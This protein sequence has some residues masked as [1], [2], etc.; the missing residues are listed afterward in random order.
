MLLVGAG[1]GMGA[2]AV[3]ADAIV[4]DGI[5]GNS[6]EQ[7]EALV[8][9]APSEALA[10][11]VVCDRYGSLWERAGDGRLNRYAVDGRSLGAYPLP[12]SRGVQDRLSLVGDTLVLLVNGQV[13]TLDVN[14]APN[15]APEKMGIQA[16]MIS[17]A[18][19][20][21]RL[22]VV[23]GQD[24]GWL[25]V[26]TRAVQ[27]TAHLDDRPNRLGVDEHGALVVGVGGGN[28]I[29]IEGGKQRPIPQH[30]SGDRL[31]RLGNAW[32]A[33]AWHGTIQR[34]DENFAPAPGVVLG[35]NSGSF[36][37]TVDENLELESG[38]GLAQLPNGQFA[39]SGRYGDLFLLQWDDGLRQFQIVRR[40]SASPD[41]PGLAL[42]SQGR[43]WTKGGV[44]RWEDGPADSTSLRQLTRIGGPVS[45][46]GDRA[47]VMLGP[48]RGKL[49]LSTGTFGTRFRDKGV[50]TEAM[51]KKPVGTVIYQADKTIQ[52]LAVD[53][54][55]HFGALE[56]TSGGELRRAL[57]A[58]VVHPA[59][60]LKQ[61]S[62]LAMKDDQ[63]LLAAADGFVVEFTRKGSAWVESR[64]WNHCE[65]QESDA[66]GPRIDLAADA[67]RIWI[68]DTDRQRIMCVDAATRRCLGQFGATD[69]GGTG[70]DHLQQPGQLAARGVR[71]IVF[72]EGNQRLVKLR[73]T[74]QNSTSET[75]IPATR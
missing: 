71:A 34:Y 69:Q 48:V 49:T 44:W 53:A 14:A 43:V 60:P 24:V 32:Y 54:G 12:P 40:I 64:R 23:Q 74:P 62:S 21:G 31:Q 37:G 57:D 45:Q 16:D 52:L 47:M 56:L 72:D 36:I 28:L 5:L 13:Y 19:A 75:T 22:G 26:K 65:G 1:L 15:T 11:G 46:L 33:H 9:F 17:S 39:V 61:W 41:C 58:P 4:C 25:N 66:F 73:W 2:P 63:T 38:R 30:L 10:M 55:G 35:G 3:Q 8:R 29:R 7:G 70:R 68:S 67:G 50:G 42:D 51:P 59:A 20:D 27:V 6:G 18:N